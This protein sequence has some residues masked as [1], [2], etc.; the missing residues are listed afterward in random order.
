MS[1]VNNRHPTMTDP[2]DNLKL[3][4]LPANKWV[5]SHNA[6]AVKIV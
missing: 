2:F 3:P 6:R 5:R 1:A 4:D